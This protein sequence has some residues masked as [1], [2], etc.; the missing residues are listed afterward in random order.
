MS[1]APSEAEPGS[2]ELYGRALREWY[3]GD[4]NATLTLHSDLGEHDEIPVEL[5]FRGPE[6]FF[7]FEEAALALAR[8]R[9]LDLGAGTGVHALPLQRSGFEVTAVERVPEAIEILRDRGVER[10]IE[11]DMFA[12]DPGR[13]D[14]VLMLM[15]GIGPVGTL[16]GLDRFLATAGRLLAPGGQVLVD[17]GEAVP[18]KPGDDASPD[19]A[20]TD[21]PSTGRWQGPEEGAY[22]G[23]AWIR[24]EYRNVVGAPFRELYVDGDTLATRA[25]GAGWRFEPAF[26]DGTGAYLARLTRRR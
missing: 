19:D 3:D 25:R 18:S 16:D 17:S 4:R 14:T 7:P 11:G 13:F 12:L 6:A 26:E 23:E 15:N 24:L 5:F 21:D 10:V 2:L 20:S 9:V 1:R 22:R 8:G